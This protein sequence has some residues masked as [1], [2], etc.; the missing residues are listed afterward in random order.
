MQT[1]EEIQLY[2]KRENSQKNKNRL[3]TYFNKVYLCNS[4]NGF[5][6]ITSN[7]G[8]LSCDKLFAIISWQFFLIDAIFFE[9]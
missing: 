4:G 6:V 8:A 7:S 1:N 5:L 9:Q 3:N 2:Q